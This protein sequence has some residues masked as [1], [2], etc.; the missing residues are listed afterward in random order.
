MQSSENSGRHTAQKKL[1]FSVCVG[2]GVC[3]Y[4]DTFHRKLQDIDQRKEMTHTCR[5]DIKKCQFRRRLEKFYTLTWR[6]QDQRR[7]QMKLEIFK[8]LVLA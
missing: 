3:V 2:V 5:T 4:I 1:F 8:F 6:K 7:W